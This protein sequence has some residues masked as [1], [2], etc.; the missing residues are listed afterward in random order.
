MGESCCPLGALMLHLWSECHTVT[1]TLLH[2]G[3]PGCGP[4]CFVSPSLHT[5]GSGSPLEPESLHWLYVEIPVDSPRCWNLLVVIRNESCFHCCHLDH[6]KP[7]SKIL[8]S[9]NIQSI[10]RAKCFICC[11]FLLLRSFPVETM[12]SLH[13]V[14]PA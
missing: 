10:A 13:C 4:V 5:P 9:K 7:P 12:W 1:F 11:R 6:L 14:L 2:S 3:P 8:P